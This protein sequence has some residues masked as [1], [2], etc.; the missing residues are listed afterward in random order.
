MARSERE[1]YPQRHLET[2]VVAV[3]ANERVCALIGNEVVRTAVARCHANPDETAVHPRFLDLLALLLGDRDLRLQ[4]FFA[5]DRWRHDVG[6]RRRRRRRLRERGARA[7]RARDREGGEAKRG[8]ARHG[9]SRWT[10][11]ACVVL[12]A[13]TGVVGSFYRF[14]IF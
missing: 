14:S 3:A 13:T 10:R 4:L 12:C 5:R 9:T 7:E 6:R 1:K 2:G 8:M 11:D